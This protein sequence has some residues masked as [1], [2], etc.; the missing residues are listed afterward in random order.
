MADAE[1]PSPPPIRTHLAQM[2]LEKM[3]AQEANAKR[4]PGKQSLQQ[5]DKRHVFSG[6][7]SSTNSTSSSQS[8]NSSYGSS[9]STSS[10]AS[11]YNEDSTNAT[12]SGNISEMEYSKILDEANEIKNKGNR[13]VNSG[14]YEMA[15]ESYSM[16]I[17][18]IDKEPIYYTNRALCYLK[19][20]RLVRISLK[21]SKKMKHQLLCL[22]SLKI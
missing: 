15:L 9:S 21:I 17:K 5:K 20:A 6:P 16:A 7:R 10:I 11:A 14:D 19:L 1:K 3:K 22:S 18:L 13:Y 8:S 4:L 12:A 2:E